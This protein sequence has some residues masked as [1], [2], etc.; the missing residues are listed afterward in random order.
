[1]ESFESQV[2]R[3][4]NDERE[5][6]GCS[7]LRLDSRLRT[8]ARRQSTDMARF[9]YMSHTGQD[10]SDPGQRMRAAGY[11]TSGGWA[12]NVARGY[13]TPS[14]VMTGWMNSPGH[15]ANILNCSLH[16]LGVGVVRSSGGRYYWTQDFGVR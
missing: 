6:K 14:A 7:R 13:P 5:E 8:A 11:D 9:G 3:L 12:E 1:V 4:T 16:A 2:L 10:G 15:R